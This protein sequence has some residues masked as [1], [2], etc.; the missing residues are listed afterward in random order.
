MASTMKTKTRIE[1]AFWAGNYLGLFQVFFCM[2][3]LPRAGLSLFMSAA[4]SAIISLVGL[5][6]VRWALIVEGDANATP[7]QEQEP[8]TQ[9]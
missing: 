7:K 2:I 1:L 5:R 9:K 6:L 3:F 4:I 8:G